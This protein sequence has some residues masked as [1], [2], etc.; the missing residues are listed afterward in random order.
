MKDPRKLLMQKI[1]SEYVWF[2]VIE[3]KDVYLAS[4]G[5]AG[6]MNR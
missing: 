1:A 6:V 2:A 3:T 5:S 4:Q